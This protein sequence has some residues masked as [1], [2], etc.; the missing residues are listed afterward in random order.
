MK[1]PYSLQ[2]GRE[3][4]EY[5]SRLEQ[6]ETV[7]NSF[8]NDEM[9]IFMVTGV[10]GA[11]KTAFMSNIKYEFTGL[12]DWVV[13]EVGT[14]KDMLNT[15]AAKLSSE[16]KLGELF[17]SA[18][19]NLSYLG[20]G[21][22]I[23]GTQPVTDIDVA[24]SRML[25]VLK[26]HKKKLLVTVDEVIDNQYV[27]EFATSF[28]ILIR[29]KLPIYL[30]MTG[31]Y[32]NID[33]LQN[34]KNLTFLHRAP[35]IHLNP[36]NIGTMASSYRRNIKVDDKSS[37]KMAQ[38]TKGYPYAF[39]VLGYLSWKN[40][41]NYEEVIDDFKQYLDE[42]VYDKIWSELS[43]KDKYVLYGIAS[44]DSGKVSDIREFLKL[45]SNEYNPYVRRLK[46]KE[47]IRGD[48]R[49]YVEFVLPLFDRF[50]IENYYI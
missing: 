20:F 13:I 17:K 11:G 3:P 30:L 18:R 16:N 41:G 5:I 39:Q 43:P 14:E 37:I 2:F 45:T 49:G 6:K 28:Q 48:N 25:E 9:Q 46:R 27:R 12:K 31:L 44:V 50:V 40:K 24:L 23:N 36:L 34:E 15:L 42:Y 4:E 26:K 47:I 8:L 33:E 10:R 38:L 22:E 19:I 21:I 35:K 29:D 7:I 1:N 32:N